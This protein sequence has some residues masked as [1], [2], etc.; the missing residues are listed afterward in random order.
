M[1]MQTRVKNQPASLEEEKTSKEKNKRKRKNKK[2][3]T[4]HMR[5]QH[6]AIV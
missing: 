3:T 1:K 5:L 4:K 6:K 2:K